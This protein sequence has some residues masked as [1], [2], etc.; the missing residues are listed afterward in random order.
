MLGMASAA[1]LVLDGVLTDANLFGWSWRAVFFVNVPVAV[2]APAAGLLAVPETRDESARRPNYAGAIVPA[3]SMVA[4]AY[5]LLEGRQLGWPAWVWPVLAV[6]VAGLTRLGVAEARRRS[7]RAAPLLSAWL[8]RA[9]FFGSVSSGHSFAAA[10]QHSAPY[11][12]GAFALCGV[13]SLLLPRA[14]VSE[15]VITDGVAASAEGGQLERV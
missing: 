6:G 3:V 1:G 9:V 5:P 2:I 13:L 11:A 7:G 14:A 10:L 8:L 4:I 15:E 12:I